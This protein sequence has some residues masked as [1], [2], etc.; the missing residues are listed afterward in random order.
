[1][2]FFILFKIEPGVLWRKIAYDLNSSSN[3]V[4]NET[5]LITYNK[6]DSYYRPLSEENIPIDFILTEFHILVLFKNKLRVICCL[7]DQIIMD[8]KFNEPLI[9]ICKDLV[10]GT[11]WVYSSSSVYRYK[12]IN[13]ERDIWRI[14]LQ[15]KDFQKAK[16]FALN[17]G[18]AELDV[19]NLEEAQYY[20]DKKEYKNFYFN[21]FFIL[22]LLTYNNFLF[23]LF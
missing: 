10:N 12:I 23:I 14:Y 4:S 11:I 2:A 22:I 7:N 8:D 21:F 13:E 16:A 17:M 6:E 1:M 20:F 15:K 3:T 9:G 5:C 18:S 19:V